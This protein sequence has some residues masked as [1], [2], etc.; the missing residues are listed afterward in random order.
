M[1]VCVFVCVCTFSDQTTAPI[2]TVDGSMESLGPWSGHDGPRFLKN[3]SPTEIT[4]KNGQ[5]PVILAILGH[6]DLS[7]FSNFA[8]LGLIRS[9]VKPSR[10]QLIAGSWRTVRGRSK[11]FQLPPTDTE[12]AFSLSRPNRLTNFVVR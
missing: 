11:Q 7:P 6:W 1:C 9:P 4:A 2:L 5:K 8:F 10:N 12:N 3:V